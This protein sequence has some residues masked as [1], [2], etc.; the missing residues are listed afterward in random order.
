[1]CNKSASN[2]TRNSI[3]FIILFSS[4]TTIAQ[5]GTVVIDDPTLLSMANLTQYVQQVCSGGHEVKL[6]VEG[7]G[8]FSPS[9]PVALVVNGKIAG[10]ANFT[11]EEWIGTHATA[12]TYNDCIKQ[13]L[14]IYVDKFL[15]KK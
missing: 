1:M 6:N 3:F 10:K 5:V 12:E 7:G 14:P 11:K 15:Q 13:V 9:K 8:E 2:I 4:T